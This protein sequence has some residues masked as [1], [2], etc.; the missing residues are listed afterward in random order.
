MALPKETDSHASYTDQL[1]YFSAR[2][3]ADPTTAKLAA[4][5]D[6]LVDDLDDAALALRKA[7]RAEVRARARRDH[8]DNLGDREIQ[9]FRRRI[10]SFETVE[11]VTARLFPRGVKHTIAPRGRPQLERLG[12]LLRSIDELLGS[13][14]LEAYVESKDL[15]SLLEQGKQQVE[16]TREGLREQIVAWEAQVLELSRARDAFNFHRSNGRA[17]VGVV[18]GELRAV[19]GGSQRA[20]YSYTQAARAADSAASDE[21]DELD[22]AELTD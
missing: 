20:A 9:R 18:L 10:R 16:D 19:L 13:T 1:V 15:Q 22:D 14:R 17:R 21:L 6:A 11:F 7:R 5:V 2:L 12:A 8:R 3:D 4:K